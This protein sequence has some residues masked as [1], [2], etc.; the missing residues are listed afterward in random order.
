MK[1]FVTGRCG[2]EDSCG[3]LINC[4]ELGPVTEGDEVGKATV[5]DPGLPVPILDVAEGEIKIKT[6]TS[7]FDQRGGLVYGLRATALRAAA[8]ERGVSMAS[9]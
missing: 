8:R 6:P 3:H 7:L 2:A 4:A 5:G 9:Q 1:C